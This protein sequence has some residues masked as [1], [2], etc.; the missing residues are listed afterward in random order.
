MEA[1]RHKQSYQEPLVQHHDLSSRL[2]KK[3][4]WTVSAALRGY[5]LEN[6][7]IDPDRLDDSIED[8]V[9]D[10]MAKD[11]EE[12]RRRQAQIE[13]HDTS[14]DSDHELIM[15]LRQGD[16]ARFL[17]EFTKLTRLRIN[18]VRRILFEAGGECLASVCKSAGLD[19]YTF[20]TIF[21]HFRQGRLG[22]QQVEADEL[23][24]AVCFYDQ[25]EMDAARDLVR[26]MKRD[27]DYLNALRQIGQAAIQ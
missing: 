15:I 1:S 4:Y 5:I 6:F 19:Q 2:A 21:V 11:E 22:D 10:A 3:L 18:L 27:P 16:I 23:S 25:V 13:P 24:R 9:A 7:D 20:I 14:D 12:T 8:S 26:H 17:D